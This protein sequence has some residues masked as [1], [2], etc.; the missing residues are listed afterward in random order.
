MQLASI[1]FDGEKK[2][3]SHFIIPAG[4][5]KK[6]NKV[7]PAIDQE[8][9]VD[10]IN[11]IDKQIT[12]TEKESNP[13]NNDLIVEE[14][15]QPSIQKPNL[16]LETRRTSALSIS[17]IENQ[18][19]VVKKNLDFVD[20]SLLPRDA[21]TT[22]QL[23]LLWNEFSQSQLQSGRKLK[24]AILT[25]STPS[26]NDNQINYQVASNNMKEQFLHIAPQLLK[27]LKERL[28]NYGIAFNIEVAETIQTK[29]AHSPREKYDLLVKKNAELDLLRERFSLEL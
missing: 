17:N 10:A 27:F 4:Y 8:K 3:D 20:E 9:A 21:F 23:V 28:N 11:D 19:E 7:E 15:K 5:F 12:Y 22:D 13:N 25:S 14:P 1:T 18:K 29:Y 16:K 24:N 26:C 6:S 2:N